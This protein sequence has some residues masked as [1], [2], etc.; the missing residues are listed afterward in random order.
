VVYSER[1]TAHAVLFLVCFKGIMQ[2][3]ILIVLFATLVLDAV[4]F[5][6]VIPIIPIVLTDPMSPSFILQGFSVQSQ[7]LIAGFVTAVFGIMQFLGAP[8]LGELSDVY[9]RKKLLTLGIAALALSQVLF[10]FAIEIGA[11]WLL[12]VSRIVGGLAAANFAIAQA[13]IADVTEPKDRAKNFGLVGA[14]LGIGFIIGPLLSGWMVHFFASA[15]APFWFAAMLGLMNVISVSLFMPET[16]KHIREAAHTF[17]IL[18][19][20]QNIKAA[21]N[22]VDVRPVY[23]TSFLYISGFSFFVA[24]SGIYLVQRFGLSPGEIG[25][26]FGVVGGW[27]IFTQGV[28]LRILTRYFS[29]RQILRVSI[30]MMGAGLSIYSF[31]PSM[32]L[33]YTIMPMIAIGNGLSIAN[34]SALVSKGVSGEKQGAALGING[35]LMALGNGVIPIVAGTVSGVFGIGMPFILGSILVFTAWVVLFGRMFLH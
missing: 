15:S 16:R 20:M 23:A 33:V 30:L 12:F 9:G 5:G 11:L 7:F 22:D 1:W 8:V 25:T 29:E 18:K 21:L 4:S 13:T 19:G 31:L 26:F 35:S 17:H 28:L 32:A 24:F 2:K 6:I 27:I 14:A 10:G 3:R 34:I